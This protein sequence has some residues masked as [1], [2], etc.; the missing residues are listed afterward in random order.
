MVLSAVSTLHYLL[1]LR[2]KLM[3]KPPPFQQE[4]S[5]HRISELQSFFFGEEG[6]RNKMDSKTF[7]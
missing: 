4:G 2:N 3:K 1:T 7:H 5:W 6:K